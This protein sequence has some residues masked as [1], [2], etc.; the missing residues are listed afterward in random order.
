MVLG[1]F[2][3]HLQ[4]VLHLAIQVLDD[5]AVVQQL[6]LVL[7]EL[8]VDLCQV[9]GDDTRLAIVR[10]T[11]PHS[12]SCYSELD[13]FPIDFLESIADLRLIGL[14]VFSDNAHLVRRVVCANGPEAIACSQA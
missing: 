10:S 4:V 5:L 14:A 9:R 6:F 12:K 8:V 2:A 7:V 3:D 1:P 11:N 13:N